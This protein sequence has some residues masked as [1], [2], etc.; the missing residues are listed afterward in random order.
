V[1]LSYRRESASYV[2]GRIAETISREFGPASLFQDIVTI[3]AGEDADKAIDA[4][5]EDCTAMIVL[6][7][8][9]WLGGFEK[10]A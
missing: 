3:G 10:R 9:D 1:F 4:S 6:I 2:A 7:D 5:L 8:A